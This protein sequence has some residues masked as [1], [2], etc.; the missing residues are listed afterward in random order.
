MY[1]LPVRRV[2][3]CLELGAAPVEHTD[4]CAGRKSEH[5]R[6]VLGFIDWEENSIAGATCRRREE[7]R[8]GHAPAL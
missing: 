7:P 8:V 1:T 3:D 5:A 4:T 6:Q 2:Y